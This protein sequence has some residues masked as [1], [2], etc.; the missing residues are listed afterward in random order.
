MQIDTRRPSATD[1]WRKERILLSQKYASAQPA[2]EKGR[3]AE[4]DA[5]HREV[6]EFLRTY[7]GAFRATA[8]RCSLS[9]EDAED[10]LQ[11]SIEILLTRAPSMDRRARAAWMHV[12]VRHEALRIRRRRRRTTTAGDANDLPDDDGARLLEGQ[13]PEHLDPAELLERQDEFN[14]FRQSFRRL[15]GDEQRAL[16]MIG[17]GYSYAEIGTQT[18]WSYTKINRLL[19]EGRMKMRRMLGKLDSGQRCTEL[20]GPLSRFCDGEVS[21]SEERELRDHLAACTACRATL[22]SFRLTSGQAAL[23]FPLVPASGG[24]GGYL[25]EAASWL[26]SRLPNRGSLAEAALGLPGGGGGGGQGGFATLAKLAVVCAGIGGGTGAC[27]ATGVLPSPNLSGGKAEIANTAKEREPTAEMVPIA[28]PPT[29]AA[30]PPLSPSDSDSLADSEDEE[31]EGRP[32]GSRPQEE[33]SQRSPEQDEFGLEAAGQQITLPQ[34]SAQSAGSAESRPSAA[35][36]ATAKSAS[37][38]GGAALAPAPSNKGQPVPPTRP[39]LAGG[40]EF[41]P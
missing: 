35:S 28:P 13:R 27:L 11:R 20:S 36:S 10:A 34:A 6:I 31:S 12:V 22:R 26:Q 24:L 9:S 18:G 3:D 40:G 37:G 8:H 41:A 33:A 16:C 2:G 25:Q 15:K 38:G 29:A 4:P 23:V 7:E 32:Q 14:R 5:R 30:S 19:A 17:E 39:P 1:T 21:E